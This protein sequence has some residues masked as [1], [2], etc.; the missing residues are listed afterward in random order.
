V[1]GHPQGL[2]YTVSSGLVSQKR[3]SELIQI[4][5]PISPGNSGGPVYD[6]RG[7][8]IGIVEAV[9]DKVRSPNAENLNFAVRAD[10]LLK[11]RDWD[12][13]DIGKEKLRGLIEAKAEEPSENPVI[14]S[15]KTKTR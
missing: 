4:S 3:D 9:I 7:N 8:L 6:S 13:T 2:T 12:L 15:E 14:P 5:A 11:T 1:I 10:I